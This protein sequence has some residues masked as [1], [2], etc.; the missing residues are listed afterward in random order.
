MFGFIVVNLVD[1]DSGMHDGWLNRLLL[2][3]WL[4]GLWGLSVSV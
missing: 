1:G 2:N 3:D 4:N